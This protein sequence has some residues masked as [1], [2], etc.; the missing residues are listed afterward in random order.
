MHHWHVFNEFK[1]AS[2]AAADF[3][4]EHISNVLNIKDTCHVALPGGNTP[5][6]CLSYL[7][8]KDIPWEKVHWYLGDERCVERSH[9]SRNDLMLEI[10]FWSRLPSVNKYS[11]PA[12]LGP[13]EAAQSY[14]ETISSI[15]NFD[16]AFLGLGEDGHT[17]S[18]F[19]DNIALTDARAVVPVF[20]SP[21]PPG[22]RVSVSVNTLQNAGCRMVLAAGSAKADVLSKVKKGDNLPVNVI[23]DIAWFVDVGAMSMQVAEPSS[24]A[25]H[26]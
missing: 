23:G 5:A 4:A 25:V 1:Q 20:N 13:V 12:E 9:A 19:P 6:L 17:A 2:I 21:K 16:I 8:I 7:A 24:S 10:N 11:I 3:I 22:E 15:N 18:L 14:S 26:R